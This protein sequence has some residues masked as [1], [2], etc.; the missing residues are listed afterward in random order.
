MINK[1][2]RIK[3]TTHINTNQTPYM[4]LI[5]RL[6]KVFQRSVGR[7]HP[8]MKITIIY[9]RPFL[10]VNTFA[11][12]NV[13]KPYFMRLKK[14]KETAS[15]KVVQRLHCNVIDVPSYFNSDALCSWMSDILTTKRSQNRNAFLSQTYSFPSEDMN[16][17]ESVWASVLVCVFK[18]RRKVTCSC[19]TAQ[20]RKNDKTT[21]IFWVNIA[22]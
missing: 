10:Q 18:R 15:N 11:D 20:G 7:V 6:D 1:I 19:G 9:E 12:K 13:Y 3:S 2:V 21:F 5:F 16:S 17:L 22:D 8:N 4:S 14:Q